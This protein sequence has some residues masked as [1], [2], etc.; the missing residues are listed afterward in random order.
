MADWVSEL[1]ND[2]FRLEKFA[3]DVFSVDGEMAF[4]VLDVS[5]TSK[6]GNIKA[7]YLKSLGKKVTGNCTLSQIPEILDK[8]VTSGRKWRNMRD[9]HKSF[10]KHYT[11]RF[12][13]STGL[14]DPNIVKRYIKKS[15]GAGFIVFIHSL[16][17]SFFFVLIFV[18]IFRFDIPNGL[19]KSIGFHNFYSSRIW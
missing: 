14:T 17:L 10:N 5:H 16:L 12:S 18:I 3:D 7:D 15:Q 2:H 1:P 6:K 13:K 19:C 8:F 9:H 4:R 11:L